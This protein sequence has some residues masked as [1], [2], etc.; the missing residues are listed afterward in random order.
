MDQW[1]ARFGVEPAGSSRSMV[2]LGRSQ[3]R[4]TA[5]WLE[6]PDGSRHAAAR[7]TGMGQG[8][9]MSLAPT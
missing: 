6:R 5:T 2:A 3:D 1:R 4:V 9:E 7:P 8:C